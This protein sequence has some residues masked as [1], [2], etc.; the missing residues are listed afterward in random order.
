MWLGLRK[1]V[2]FC[3]DY[4]HWRAR[5]C[6]LSK[7]WPPP[8]G[9]GTFSRDWR[10]TCLIFKSRI[11]LPSGIIRIS[12]DFIV[13]DELNIGFILFHELSRAGACDD[14]WIL[15]IDS[16]LLLFSYTTDSDCLSLLLLCLDLLW[17]SHECYFYA[18]FAC[19]PLFFI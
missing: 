14:W 19:F 12:T 6:L 7:S 9:V 13:A 11:L 1:K 15:I 16:I 2:S 5:L 18:Y 4:T 3:R 17:L 10:G 8:F